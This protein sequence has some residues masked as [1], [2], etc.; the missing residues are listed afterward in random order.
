MNIKT[1]DSE[2]RRN[3]FSKAYKALS[4]METLSDLRKQHL[5]P[6]D[7]SVVFGAMKELSNVETDKHSYILSE[8][9]AAWFDRQGFKVEKP[10]PNS[11]N[12]I[13]C[14]NY[15]ISVI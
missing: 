15:C 7:Y 3:I 4:E 2:K 13:A 1:T 10:D 6:Y 5:T 8:S 11:A 12:Y 9:A 14:V